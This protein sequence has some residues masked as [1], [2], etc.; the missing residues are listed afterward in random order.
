MFRQAVFPLHVVQGVMLAATDVHFETT[1]LC[2]WF[3]LLGDTFSLG[4]EGSTTPFS[5]DILKGKVF[6]TPRC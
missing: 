6:L 4:D 1:S 3:R 5:V 2:Q